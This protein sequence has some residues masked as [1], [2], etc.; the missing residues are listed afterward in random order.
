MN[1]KLNTAIKKSGYSKIE[2]AEKLGISRSYLYNIVNE[3]NKP[4]HDITKGLLGLL[5]K[6]FEDIFINDPEVKK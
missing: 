5:N 3:V 6:K 4:S 1:E 2:V